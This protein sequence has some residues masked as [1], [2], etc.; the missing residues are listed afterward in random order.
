MQRDAIRKALPS[1]FENNVMTIH[2][3][4][5]REWDTVIISVCDNDTTNRDVK[6]RFTSSLEPYSGLNVINTAVSRAKKNLIIVCDYEFWKG[7]AP[8]DDLIGVLVANTD[9][10]VIYHNTTT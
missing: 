2:S 9:T 4:Q 5:G 10:T 8:L 7:R 6:L 1:K 3:S